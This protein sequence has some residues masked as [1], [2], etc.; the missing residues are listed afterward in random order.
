MK[1]LFYFILCSC[2]F[3]NPLSVA[4]IWIELNFLVYLLK[5]HWFYVRFSLHYFWI[6]VFLQSSIDK[7]FDRK[8]N[9]LF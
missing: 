3:S 1:K 7:I 6:I 8:N 5:I 4:N 9:Q 2:S